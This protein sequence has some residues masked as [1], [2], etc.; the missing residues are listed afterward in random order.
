MTVPPKNINGT[1]ISGKS[2]DRDS[3]VFVFRWHICILARVY[4]AGIVKQSISFLNPRVRKP[5]H[6]CGVNRKTSFLLLG[7]I[8]FW[9]KEIACICIIYFGLPQVTTIPPITQEMDTFKTWLGRI[10]QNTPIPR[11]A[12]YIRKSYQ[13][14]N[15]MYMIHIYILFTY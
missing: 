4:T 10:E 9:Q 5:S 1:S 8:Y 7:F 15:Y 12:E 6:I 14:S 13:G 2:R 3:N 11:Y